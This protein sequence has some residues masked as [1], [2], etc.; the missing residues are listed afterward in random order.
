[1]DPITAL[2][3]IGGFLRPLLDPK[4]WLLLALAGLAGFIHGCQEEKERHAT[5]MTIIERMGEEHKRWSDQR[6]AEQK[7]ITERKDAEHAKRIKNLTAATADLR[8]KLRE[9]TDSFEVPAARA[10][11]PGGERLGVGAVC[12]DRDR[13]G[14]GIRRSLQRFS[15]RLAALAERGGAGIANFGTCAE[16]A[17]DQ[18]EAALR[19]AQPVGE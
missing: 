5:T 10:P 11:A 6:R 7:A 12:F 15:E 19:S 14:E 4:V 9:R 1:M 17:I 2:R 18:E 13:L 8:R 3:F 16:W